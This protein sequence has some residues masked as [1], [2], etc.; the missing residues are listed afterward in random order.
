M[1]RKVFRYR[2]VCLQGGEQTHCED[3]WRFSRKPDKQ[4]GKG[5]NVSYCFLVAVYTLDVPEGTRKARTYCEEIRMDVPG[6]TI[7]LSAYSMV[8]MPKLN[9]EHGCERGYI[10]IVKEEWIDVRPDWLAACKGPNGDRYIGEE[11]LPIR[12]EVT[13]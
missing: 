4:S 1:K 7:S 2:F 13:N 9:E 5:A 3:E 8:Q 6:Y 12:R 11:K 10:K